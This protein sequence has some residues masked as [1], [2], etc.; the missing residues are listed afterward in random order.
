[1]DAVGSAG[2]VGAGGAFNGSPFSGMNFDEAAR[3]S[4]E[5]F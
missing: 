2:A 1:M 4:F 5:L 3:T